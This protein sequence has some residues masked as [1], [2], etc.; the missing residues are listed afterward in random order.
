MSSFGDI[1]SRWKSIETMLYGLCETETVSNKCT[2]IFSSPSRIRENC[3]LV[4]DSFTLV[5]NKIFMLRTSL[6]LSFQFMA[7]DVHKIDEKP[8]FFFYRWRQAVPYSLISSCI[9]CS[10]WPDEHCLL[11]ILS[12]VCVLAGSGWGLRG[13][14]DHVNIPSPQNLSVCRGWCIC[15]AR[16]FTGR[17]MLRI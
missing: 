7:A 9:S 1:K 13:R 14:Q 8:Y 2:A 17:R 4:C 3:V 16:L 5:M 12:S 11:V 10:P 6:I 15:P